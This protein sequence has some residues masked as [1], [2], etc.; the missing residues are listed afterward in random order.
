MSTTR[1][2]VFS[3]L[4]KT[5]QSL[6]MLQQMTCTSLH[7]Q[8]LFRNNPYPDAVLGFRSTSSLLL[9]LSYR[10]IVLLN[11]DSNFKDD[12]EYEPKI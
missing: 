12:D 3:L 1:L 10:Y 11:N 9:S 7:E 2:S 4:P 5:L 8:F 6:V